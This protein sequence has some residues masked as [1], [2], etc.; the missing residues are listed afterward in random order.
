MNLKYCPFCKTTKPV[1]KAGTAYGAKG[2]PKQRYYCNKCHRY[3]IKPK[4]KR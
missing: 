2:K 1:V 3:T 4:T